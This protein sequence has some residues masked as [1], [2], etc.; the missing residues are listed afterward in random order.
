MT[1]LP[2]LDA[3]LSALR[4][5][6]LRVGF[7]E[8]ARL[9]RIFALEPRVSGGSEVV[10]RRLKSL[11]RA[12]IVKTEEDRAAFESVCDAWLER[13]EAQPWLATRP[14]PDVPTIA[15]PP[16][17]RLRP[18]WGAAALVAVIVVVA[19][20]AGRFRPPS[21]PAVPETPATTQQPAE[22]APEARTPDEVHRDRFTSWVPTVTVTEA[23]PPWGGWPALGLC[24][25]ALAATAVFGI[26]LYRRRWLP[27]PAPAPAR[28]GPPQVFLETPELPGL[29]LLD[30][31]EEEALVWGIGCF[32]ADEPTRRLDL[33][34]TVRATARAGG[35]PELCFHLARYHREVWLWLDAAADDPAILRLA[36]EIETSLKAHGLPVERAQFRGIP[37][38]LVNDAGEV[39]APREVDERREVALVAVLTDGRVL[40]RQYA[41]DD[42]RV[43][44]DALLRLLSRWPRVWLVD[45]SDGTNDLPVIAARH[46]LEVI[47]PCELAAVLGN[48]TV[49]FSARP[50][51]KAPARHDDAAW[52][53]AC[54]LAPTSV[55]EATAFELRRHLGLRTTPWALRSMRAAAPGPP[56]RLEWAA[57]KRVQLVNWL[58]DVEGKAD[59]GLAAESL[60]SRALVFWGK[61]YESEQRRRER[62]DSEVPWR[63]TPAQQHLAMERALVRLWRHARD[64]VRDLYALFQGSLQEM[65]RR[66][67]GVLAS[68]DLGTD[69]NIRMPWRWEERSAVER[70]MLHEMGLGGRLGA[71]G[72]RRPGRLWLSVGLGIGLSIGALIGIWNSPERT[73]QGRPTVVHGE[74]KPGGAWNREGLLAEDRWGV[75]VFTPKWLAYRETG[76]GARV[77]V[78]WSREDSDCVAT[79]AGGAE[80]WRCGSL[81]ALRRLP[82]EIRRS[83]VV[84]TA[85]PGT[86]DAEAL[87]IALLDSASADVVLI[88][89]EW[90]RHSSAVISDL[91]ESD[92]SAQLLVISVSKMPQWEA[93]DRGASVLA[94]DGWN[95][96]AGALQFDGAQTVE[97]TWPD[98]EVAGRDPEELV[99]YGLSCRPVEWT[100]DNDM[101]FVRMCPGTFMMGSDEGDPLAFSTEKP[102]HQ[103]TLSEFWIGKYEVTNQQYRQ[104]NPD[105]E[106]SRARPGNLPVTW[107]SWDDANSFCKHLGDHLP[108][109]AEWEYAARAGTDTPW[110][111]GADDSE[112]GRYAWYEGNSKYQA[113]A[114]GILES[115]PWGLHDMHGNVWEW[116]DDEFQ[117]YSSAPRTNLRTPEASR[118]LSVVR[119]GSFRL[120]SRFL[121]SACRFRF[122]PEFRDWLLGFR[123]VRGPRRQP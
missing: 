58:H 96:L 31:R 69:A 11:L 53:A 82:H 90:P 101:V 2:G 106:E 83:V 102:A 20:I 16:R 99:L 71:I 57:A 45:F 21:E 109:E 44:V 39:F 81:G 98:V 88:D 85:P 42:R 40:S 74:G 77:E 50:A 17:R 15:P 64:A 4:S 116:V 65:I 10:R 25:V 89:A 59:G 100:D 63:D 1:E 120:T 51:P 54:A 84:L 37:E 113:R 114:V 23:Q 29:Q 105:H 108:S 3:L 56:G 68:A 46:D 97:Q 49:P 35:I 70:A 26:L 22:P 67:L 121:R 73:P 79:L 104:L 87:A 118:Q 36:N 86:A 9:K 119:G 41:A 47:A 92:S 13:L 60:L 103:V 91:T 61:R 94:L 34:A 107:V 111:F 8:V 117:P 28:K 112:I 12:V 95:Q 110:S 78:E 38:R 27:D 6:G 19:L 93:S 14:M 115:N 76:P 66:Q 24:I 55:D 30:S 7:T 33:P 80:L 18:W 52:A 48:A 62:N 72:L 122:G 32:V 75:E 43:H 123:C 5:A